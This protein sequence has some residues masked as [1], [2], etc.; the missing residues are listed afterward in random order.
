[1][2]SSRVLVFEVLK[3]L[4][5]SNQAAWAGIQTTMSWN[6]ETVSK[7]IA[8]LFFLIKPWDESCRLW[9]TVTNSLR[10][11]SLLLCSARLTIAENS[12]TRVPWCQLMTLSC[13]LSKVRFVLRFH[14]FLP[15][16]N[17][18]LVLWISRTS[19]HAWYEQTCLPSLHLDSTIMNYSC[20]FWGIPGMQTRAAVLIMRFLMHVLDSHVHFHSAWSC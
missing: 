3:S 18:F 20:G 2:P 13:A 15:Y 11:G 4:K 12:T 5:Y 7:T 16:V 6:V 17:A 9:K 10:A 1:M 19:V 8:C 14:C